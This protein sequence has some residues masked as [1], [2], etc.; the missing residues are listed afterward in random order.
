MAPL[1]LLN[2]ADEID[3]SV[4]FGSK[5]SKQYANKKHHIGNR[6]HVENICRGD[7]WNSET[8]VVH[9]QRN[10]RQHERNNKNGNGGR[11]EM[12]AAAGITSA[13]SG[14]PTSISSDET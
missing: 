4:R 3:N 13:P 1:A 7:D 11:C 5:A 9:Q 10:D 6:E 12:E 14:E 2:L 8:G